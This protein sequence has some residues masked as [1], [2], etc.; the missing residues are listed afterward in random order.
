MTVDAVNAR[1]STLVRLGLSGAISLGVATSATDAHAE[2]WMA[3]GV[4]AVGTGLQGG[5]PGNGQV[6]WT[7][8]RT[9]VLA[10]IDLRNDEEQSDGLGFYG[11]AEVERR[12]SFGGE[13]RYERWWT[14]T[15][16]FHAAVLGTFVPETMVGVGVGARLGFPI[17]RKFTLF[18]EPGV[19]AFPIGSDLPGKSVLIW[20]TLIGG[21][22][23]AL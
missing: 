3:N 12:T 5:D 1:S 7:R 11:F 6:G 9:R 22:G 14:S 16:A 23:V 2:G 17:G 10:G 18:L 13:V 4:F 21:F 8:A 20:G 19:A 15:I